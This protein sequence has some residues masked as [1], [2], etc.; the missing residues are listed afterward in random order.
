MSVREKLGEKRLGI[1]VAVGLL[2]GATAILA[3]E[4]W[5]RGPHFNPYQ[6]YYTDDD[7]KTFYKDSIYNFPPY[8]HDGKTAVWAMV[9]EDNNG[10]RFVGY[11]LRF[12]PETLKL[13]QDKYSEGLK[14][15]T[16]EASL[17]FLDTPNISLGG[18]EAKFPGQ[19][20]SWVSRGRMMRPPIK[21][22]DGSGECLPVT[23]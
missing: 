8:D 2:I 21:A 7:G 18:M 20:H 4:L 23:P 16:P 1:G 3:F 17:T 9:Y 22:P 11:C 6:S 13:V 10:H 19:D 15:G 5:P 12:K 14:N